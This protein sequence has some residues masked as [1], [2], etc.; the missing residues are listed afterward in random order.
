MIKG[1]TEIFKNDIKTIISNPV[2]LIVL[3]IIICIPSLYTLVNI[4]AVWNPY[5]DT[6]NMKIAIVDNDA[7]YTAQGVN[8]DFGN[9]LTNEL[10][11]NNTNFNWQFVDENTARTGVENGVYYAAFIIP[12]NFTENLLSMETVN[13]QQAQIHYIVNE[14]LNPVA[15]RLTNAT[16]NTLQSQINSAVDQAKINLTTAKANALQT[17][18]TQLTQ[19]VNQGNTNSTP[20]NL[21]SAT[22]NTNNLI[23][24]SNADSND[25]TVNPVKMYDETDYPVNNYGSAIAPFYIALSLF[26]GCI[27]AAAMLSTRVRNGKKYHHVSVYLG[28]M[29]LFIII[30]VFQAL[31]IALS[32]LNLHVQVSSAT[33][34]TLTVLYIGLCFMIVVY[35]LTSAFGNLGKMLAIILLVFQIMATGGTFPVQT[36][37]PFFQAINPYLPMTYAIE[38]LRQVVA[39]VLWSRYWYNIEILALFPTLLFTLTLLI[40]DKVDKKAEWTEIKLKESGLF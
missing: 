32:V 18:L 15:P 29:G 11:V 6:S 33:I 16:A 23:T 17:Q 2:V 36:L 39:G 10:A 26:I 25:P 20:L 19:A 37:P 3:I 4:N 31:I 22:G 7:G 38:A 14:K 12:S 1:I 21:N 5:N 9:N 28:R 35:S 34:L 27:I 24:F 40:K 13:P 30:S 8:Y